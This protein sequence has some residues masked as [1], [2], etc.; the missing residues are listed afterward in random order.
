MTS[1][2]AAFVLLAVV[3]TGG[4]IAFLRKAGPYR[5]VDARIRKISGIAYLLGGL[6]LI[7]L[8]INLALT[9]PG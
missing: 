3:Y 7:F 8:A 1:D 6:A 9:L 5:R 2:I 4:L